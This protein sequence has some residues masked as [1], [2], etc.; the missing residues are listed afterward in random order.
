MF[1][2]GYC[3]GLLATLRQDLTWR[4]YVGHGDTVASMTVHQLSCAMRVHHGLRPHLLVPRGI[5]PKVGSY[6]RSLFG[7]FLC[8]AVGHDPDLRG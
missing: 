3:H 4:Y 7:W 8:G 2:R 6:P 5:V 1:G